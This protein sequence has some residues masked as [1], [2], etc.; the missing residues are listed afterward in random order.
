MSSVKKAILKEFFT[1]EAQRNAEFSRRFSVLAPR[2]DGERI[3]FITLP[4]DEK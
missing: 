4:E 2:F 3:T 1:A